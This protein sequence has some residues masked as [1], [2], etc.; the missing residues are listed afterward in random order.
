VIRNI[1][2]AH[3]HNHL[4]PSAY[5]MDSQHRTRISNDQ[6]LAAREELPPAYSV[7]IPPPHYTYQRTESDSITR[8]RNF[9]IYQIMQDYEHRNPNPYIKPTPHDMHVLEEIKCACVRLQ[10]GTWNGVKR[11]SEQARE[12]GRFLVR[13]VDEPAYEFGIPPVLILQRVD[14][15]VNIISKLWSRHTAKAKHLMENGNM[16]ELAEKLWLDKIIICKLIPDSQQQAKK[17]LLQTLQYYESQ[18][19]EQLAGPR[20]FDPA[21]FRWRLDYRLDNAMVNV[22]PVN[23]KG[24]QIGVAFLLSKRGIERSKYCFFPSHNTTQFVTIA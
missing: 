11:T 2:S 13:E 17:A 9:L 5:I 15:W 21:A 3:F 16:K 24:Q 18:N 10:L 8:L 23:E 12:D 14:E 6:M 1:L 20:Q 19:F 4:F 7:D 22:W